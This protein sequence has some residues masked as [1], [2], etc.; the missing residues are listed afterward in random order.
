MMLQEKIYE[1]VRIRLKKERKKEKDYPIRPI[2]NNIQAPA[3]KTA[4]FMNRKL[5]E[6]LPLP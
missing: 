1:L 3:Y 4:K 2:I 6:L 5:Q